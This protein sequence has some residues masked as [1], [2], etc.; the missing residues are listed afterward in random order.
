MR[1]F[2]A[3]FCSLAFSQHL[4]AIN[5]QQFSRSNSLTYET[6]EDARSQVGHVQNNYKWLGT[7]G[8]SFVNEPLV[9]KS[10]DNDEQRSSILSDLQTVH[11][12]FAYYFSPRFQL[13]LTS[14]YSFFED[15]EENSQT[16]LN[17]LDL[18]AKFRVFQSNRFALALMPILTVPLDKKEF[19][20][21]SSNNIRFGKQALLSDSSIGYGVRFLGELTFRRL[22]IVAN[23]GYRYSEDAKFTDR[24]GVEHIDMENQLYSGIG[25]YIPVTAKWGFNAEFTR[26]WS[27]PFNSNINP[28]ELLV[29]TSFGLIKGMHGFL[30]AGFG[31]LI[32]SSDTDGN[33]I[34]L[35]GGIKFY[36]GG[37]SDKE[38]RRPIRIDKAPKPASNCNYQL[39]DHGNIGTIRFAN[40]RY[41]LVYGDQVALE[42][43]AKSI[44]DNLSIIENIEIFGH[45]SAS[46]SD[47][48][49]MKL[50]KKRALGVEEVFR[51]NGIPAGLMSTTWQGESQ[52]L[53]KAAGSLAG[54]KNRRVEVQVSFKGC[55]KKRIRS[56]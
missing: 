25:A 55:G 50:S 11:F 21:I 22:Q 16:A 33:D 44:K 7:L 51:N 31:N 10:S 20:I 52:L 47:S 37:F 9:V 43:L 6:L 4:F 39:F 26:L 3:L 40:N 46:A 23:L 42:S 12:G 34:R 15:S 13:G 17:D 30:S 24:G 29:G 32:G 8:Y 38:L 53:D 56:Y 45:A 49:N 1:F 41:S 2:L 14:G 54:K 18:K 28:N 5:V 35:S 27:L 36:L 19:E 48:Y